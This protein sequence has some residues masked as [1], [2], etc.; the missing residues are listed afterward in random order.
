MEM[1]LAK[2]PAMVRKEIWIH[3]MAYNLL[4]TLMWS[5]AMQASVAPLQVSL[6]GTRRHFRNFIASLVRKSK[7][8]VQRL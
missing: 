5:A 1:L 4:R 3:L 7:K 8:E 2:T 6:E